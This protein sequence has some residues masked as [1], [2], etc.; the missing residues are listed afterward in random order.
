VNP[1]ASAGTEVTLAV[2]AGCAAVRIDFIV[3]N[4]ASSGDAALVLRSISLARTT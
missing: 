2:P 3:D 1:T 4:S